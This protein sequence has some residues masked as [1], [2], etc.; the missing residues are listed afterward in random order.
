[1]T[2]N[3]FRDWCIQK[4]DIECNQK[5][6]GNIQYSKHLEFVVAQ[7]HRFSYL[8]EDHHLSLAEMGCWGH[9]LIEDA[10][11]TYNELKD[12]AGE[13]VANVVY[14]CTEDKGRNRDE[15]HSEKYYIELSKSRIA[16]FVKL[17]DI[18][19]NVLYSMVSNSSMYRKHENEHKKTLKY[20]YNIEFNPMFRYLDQLFKIT[21]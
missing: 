2:V 14:C 10:R 15:R 1:M 8:L 3:A 19:A 11:V 13:S 7:F 5:Y 20:L 6:D 16:T 18:I 12:I 4:H 21:Y 9:D 17:C